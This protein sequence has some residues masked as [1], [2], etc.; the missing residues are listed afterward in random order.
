M[1]INQKEAS[2][3]GDLRVPKLNSMYA[4]SIRQF[5]RQKLEISNISPGL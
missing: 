3:E 5:A 4:L 2:P 1:Q